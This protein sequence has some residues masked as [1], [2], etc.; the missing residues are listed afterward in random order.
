MVPAMGSLNPHMRDTRHRMKVPMLSH[1]KLDATSTCF[2]FWLK[3]DE[4]PFLSYQGEEIIFGL[5]L[6]C[7][8]RAILN[9]GDT[10]G[11]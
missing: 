2:R 4:T 3:E 9:L 5:C 1:Q 11:L 6:P 10:Q 8:D 7:L